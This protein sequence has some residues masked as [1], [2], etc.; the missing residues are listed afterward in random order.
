MK[1]LKL[2]MLTLMM[3]CVGVF[4]MSCKE[5]V[6]K[7]LLSVVVD[8]NTE[9]YQITDGFVESLQTTY[10]SYGMLGGQKCFTEKLSKL[11]SYSTEKFIE[12]S[13]KIHGNK[14]NYSLVY[15]SYSNTPL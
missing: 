6:F 8:P 4:S 11:F 14:Y 5:N 1:N 2:I 15:P 3:L 9:L 13:K 12:K 7:K 10:E